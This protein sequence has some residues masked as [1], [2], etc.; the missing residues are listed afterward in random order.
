MRPFLLILIITCLLAACSEFDSTKIIEPTTYQI[1]TVSLSM[2]SGMFPTNVAAQKVDENEKYTLVGATFKQGQNEII[3]IWMFNEENPEDVKSI[4]ET[5][6]NYSPFPVQDQLS[7]T[8]EA[9]NL[10][11][12][13]KR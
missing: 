2:P 6:Q 12:F 7:V 3:G 5:A 1:E 13:L 9:R 11:A 4:N 8:T 10:S